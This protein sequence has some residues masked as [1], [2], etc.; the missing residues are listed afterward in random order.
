VVTVTLDI[1][2]AL[3]RRAGLED[4]L[5]RAVLSGQLPAGTAV[6]STRGLARELGVARATVVGA[7][8]QLI[9]EGYLLARQGAGTVV[10]PVHV[11]AGVQPDMP[12][13]RP[14]YLI[15]LLPGEPDHG[16]FPRA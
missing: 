9:A 3:G 6:P 8:E 16:S 11:A 7:Y 1:D 4:A 10:A 12:P 13:G 5:R 2:S 15:D 14:P